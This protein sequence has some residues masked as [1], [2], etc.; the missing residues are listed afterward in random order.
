MS[1]FVDTSALYA[2]LVNSE[3]DHPQVAEAFFAVLL[4]GR[5]LV[6]SNYVVA[7]ASE[8]FQHRFGLTAVRDL[9]ERI[10]PLL[11]VHWITEALHRRA[12]ERLFL[13]DRP[14]ASLVDCSSF[15]LMESE[16]IRDALTLDRGFADQGFGI[17][18]SPS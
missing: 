10:L 2:L 15:V 3:E 12:V 9:E 16:G 8:L 17:I 4:Q 11:R 13:T 7:E 18:P 5:G 6:T 14:E 1:V